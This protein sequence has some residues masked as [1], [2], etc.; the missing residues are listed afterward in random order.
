MLVS[1]VAERRKLTRFV[2]SAPVRLMFG[3]GDGA[4]HVD[5]RARDL[6]AAGAYIFFSDPRLDVGDHVRIEIRLTVTDR[7]G[8]GDIPLAVPMVGAGE[9]RRVD[10]TGV[11]LAFDH[12]LRFA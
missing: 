3:Q 2:V 4:E 10:A 12:E 8:E 7:R 1:K 11:G 6:S 5:A 9:I